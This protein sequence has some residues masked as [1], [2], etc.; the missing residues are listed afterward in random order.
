MQ[1][2]ISSIQ[3]AFETLADPSNPRWATAFAFLTSHPET[4]ALM[5]ETFRETLGQMGIAPSG[6]DPLTGEPVYGVRDVAL[7]MGV[8]E[9]DLD[10]ALSEVDPRHGGEAG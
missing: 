8:P 9:A 7:A 5:T 3:E 1:D 4:A 2:A 6:T 10:A